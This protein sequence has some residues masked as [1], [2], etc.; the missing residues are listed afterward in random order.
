TVFCSN[1]PVQVGGISGTD[2]IQAIAAGGYHTC[3]LFP[4]GTVKCWG[5]NDQG[6][7]G[8]GTTQSSSTPVQV[9]GSGTPLGGAIAITGGFYHTCA[10]LQPDGTVQCWGQNDNGQ[11]GDGSTLPGRSSNPPARVSGLSGVLSVTGG[12][13]HTCALL[14]DHTVWCWG[15]N[16]SGQL[17]DGTTTSSSTPLQVGGITSAVV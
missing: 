3:A 17:G 11:L 16:D 12:F 8:D 7:L 15:L 1:T 14:G 13:R 2:N 4:N 9:G 5:R 10:I 6:Q